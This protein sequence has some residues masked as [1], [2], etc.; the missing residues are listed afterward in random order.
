M[1]GMIVR[2]EVLLLMD[3]RGHPG[4]HDGVVQGGGAESTVL[5]H[6]VGIGRNMML[7]YCQLLMSA[8]VMGA[9]LSG[10]PLVIHRSLLKGQAAG[11]SQP[12][13]QLLLSKLL[14]QQLLMCK[15]LLL[16]AQQLLVLSLSAQS[17]VLPLVQGGVVGS[18]HG[19]ISCFSIGCFCK[20]LL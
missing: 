14:L 11:F 10:N 8:A 1:V 18:H 12:W 15:L 20:L 2:I 16:L 19:L 3:G 13:M 5:G 4:V 17:R 7:W 9:T 6:I